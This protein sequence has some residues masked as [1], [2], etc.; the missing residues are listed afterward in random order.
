MSI[1]FLGASPDFQCVDNDSKSINQCIDINGN[2]CHNF[3]FNASEYKS[4]LVTKW[5][6]VCD[7]VFLVPLIQVQVTTGP[8]MSLP[9]HPL[10]SNTNPI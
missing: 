2:Q 10:I 1:L 7:K 8:Q 9:E 5:N 3:T 6:L 4:T